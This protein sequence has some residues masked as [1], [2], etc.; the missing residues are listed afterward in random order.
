MEFIVQHTCKKE[1]GKKDVLKNSPF[2]SEFCEKKGKRP[3]LGSGYYFWDYNLKYAK[4]W[5]KK[6]YSGNF[7][8]VESVVEIDYKK[9][10]YYLDLVG[11]R[12]DL[13]DFVNLLSEFDL[14][15]EGI[16]RI[17][18]CYIIEYLRTEFPEEV[19]PYKVIRAV[20]Y[21]NDKSV[22]LKISFNEKLKSYTILNPRIL[23]AYKN[24]SDIV[25]KKEPFIKFESKN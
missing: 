10:G 9:D 2:R 21:L 6:H 13:C 23:I 7:F 12:K 25:Y 19:F 8:V 24:K 4:V 15:N 5:G 3:Y 1:G 14:I 17:D 11:N 20:D 16:V 22:G 18:L